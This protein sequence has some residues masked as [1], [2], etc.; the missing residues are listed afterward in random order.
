[1]G[2]R[3]AVARISPLTFSLDYPDRSLD[4]LSTA[5]RVFT[6][7]PIAILAATLEGGSFGF[8]FGSQGARYAG[9]GIGILVACRAA[10]AAVR[11]QY[12][13]WWYDW[14]LQ[15]TYGKASPRRAG[16]P[17]GNR[18]AGASRA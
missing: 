16:R 5:V 18:V 2:C 4:R 11:K 7:I 15:L 8:G 1:M 10:D 3:R 6:I 14:N 9:G 12:P 13:R 17:V